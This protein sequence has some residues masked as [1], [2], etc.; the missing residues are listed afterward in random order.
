MT[1]AMLTLAYRANNVP[2]VNIPKA[3]GN[4]STSNSAA[5]NVSQSLTVIN[6]PNSAITPLTFVVH[7]VDVG[8]YR[9]EG[10]VM[11]YWPKEFSKY[12]CSVCSRCGVK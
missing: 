1:A 7:D 12:T 10:T 8:K 11:D 3:K 5:K 2:Y 6:T 9:V 4:T